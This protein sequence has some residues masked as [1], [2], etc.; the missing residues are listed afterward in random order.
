MVLLTLPDA[1][2][3]LMAYTRRVAALSPFGNPEQYYSGGYN[4]TE[5]DKQI[6]IKD[7]E[8]E[9]IINKDIMK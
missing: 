7:D 6:V 3:A 5:D 8:G 9:S 4:I 2:C 1:F